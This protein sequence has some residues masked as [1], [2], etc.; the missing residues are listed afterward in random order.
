M[1]PKGIIPDPVFTPKLVRQMNRSKGKTFIL[2]VGSVLLAYDDIFGVSGTDIGVVAEKFMELAASKRESPVTYEVFFVHIRLKLRDMP[3]G[4]NVIVAQKL[5]S[6]FV[7]I[8]DE[9]ISLN[10][11]N[12]VCCNVVGKLFDKKV[13]VGLFGCDLIDDDGVR[14]I[15]GFWDIMG[16][17]LRGS[18]LAQVNTVL[19]NTPRWSELH[20]VYNSYSNLRKL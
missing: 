14:V 4:T 6:P 1:L 3:W 13:R 16:E 20:T 2:K 18:E 5:V 15:F 8:H 17:K 12:K 11:Q 9:A 7:H 19:K 10:Y